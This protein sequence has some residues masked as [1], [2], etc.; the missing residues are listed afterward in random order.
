MVQEPV[1]WFGQRGGTPLRVEVEI[2][3]LSGD[4][5]SVPATTASATGRGRRAGN[6]GGGSE[7]VRGPRH[8]LRR[9]GRVVRRLLRS[10]PPG[11]G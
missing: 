5:P 7:P 1:G 2:R 11:K 4:D 10:R 3:S 6:G 9:M 8:P